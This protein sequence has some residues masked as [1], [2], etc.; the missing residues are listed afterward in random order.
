[1]YNSCVF[2]LSNPNFIFTHT[3]IVELK[4]EE[5]E[6]EELPVIS[7]KEPKLSGIKMVGDND[8]AVDVDGIERQYLTSLEYTGNKSI[9]R[10]THEHSTHNLDKDGGI[11][12]VHIT[13]SDKDLDKIEKAPVD[14]IDCNDRSGVNPNILADFMSPDIVGKPFNVVSG[15]ATKSSFNP[16]RKKCGLL[17]VLTR[18]ST[19]TRI[20][21]KNGQINTIN[22][23][24]STKFCK[25][26]FTTMIDM[27][28]GGTLS[29]FVI[30]F[31]SSWL[32]F[33]LAY[34]A[35]FWQ[36]GDF[37]PEN[38][39]GPPA[40]NTEFRKCAKNIINFAS[41]FLFSIEIQTTIG[42]GGR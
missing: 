36:H 42:F 22:E 14:V 40:N 7:V 19:K 29:V 9:L 31:F 16:F 33:A 20:V 15:S 13:I 6:S 34:Y 26:I 18:K 24:V 27:N 39:P 21:G 37:L 2:Q 25:D 12:E 32:I 10:P 1:M 28:W 38:Q 30:A 17:N 11:P 23:N 41:C 5:K 8:I 4:E 35:T 3:N